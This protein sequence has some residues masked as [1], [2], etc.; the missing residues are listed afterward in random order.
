MEKAPRIL[1]AFSFKNIYICMILCCPNCG[2]N[3]EEPLKDG[4]SIC[5]NCNFLFDNSQVNY[6]SAAGWLARKQK[7]NLDQLRYLTNL[8]EDEAC[9]VYEFCTEQ[10]YT[11]DEFIQLLNEH[12]R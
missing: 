12:F 8:T 1:G 3:L 10:G 9:F 6:L 7:F 5:E 4:V 11:H 2:Y